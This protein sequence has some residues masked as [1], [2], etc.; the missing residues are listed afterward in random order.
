MP[1][2]LPTKQPNHRLT[3]RIS[4]SIALGLLLIGATGCDGDA[5]GLLDSPVQE[6]QET[7]IVAMFS[8]ATFVLVTPADA[9]DDLSSLSSSVIDFTNDTV[10]WSLEGQQNQG[11]YAAT[12]NSRFVATFADRAVE[13]EAAGGNLLWDSV[14]YQR[15][16]RTA[17][18]SQQ[19]LT[20]TLNGS[21]YNTEALLDTGE[22]ASGEVAMGRWSVAFAD[23]QITRAVQ[24]TLS[25]GTISY[26]NDSS[27][28]ASFPNQE[29]TMVFLDGNKLAVNS[30]VYVKEPAIHFTS[31]QTLEE[32]LGGVSYQSVQ[33]L[34]LG[35][36]ANGTVALG[37]WQLNFN[38]GGFTWFY[39]DIAEAGTLTYLEPNRFN[40]VLP[41]RSLEVVTD[42]NFLV[43]DGVRYEW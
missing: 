12:S 39:Q 2:S 4:C 19:A 35:E 29:L 11:S 33:Q 30:V 32:Y 42:E 14:S 43:L 20:T 3:S 18:D 5:A 16:A 25:A 9:I 17:I 15:A 21:R 10:T 23:D 7:E 28:R 22:T 31:Q 37:H 24:D 13:F 40:A 6:E 1:S 41:N 36:T 38:N 34:P 8:G 27:F 26:I